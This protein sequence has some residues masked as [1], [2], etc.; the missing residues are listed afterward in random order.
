[1]AIRVHTQYVEALKGLGKTTKIGQWADRWEHTMK[2]IDKHKLPQASN[3][4]WLRD[5]AQA[6]KP[7]GDMLCILYGSQVRDAAQN[8]PT[9]YWMIAMQIRELFQ[10][11]AK[12]AQGTA[13]GSTFT[14]E[15][16]GEESTEGEP[17]EKLRGRSGQ[18]KHA[19]TCSIEVESSLT[20]KSK[21]QK[22]PACNIKSHSL[23]HCWTIFKSKRP[24][25]YKPNTALVKRVQEKLAKNKELKVEVEKIK[26]S[27]GIVDEA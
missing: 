12:K 4:L 10:S 17:K 26:L 14:V 23:A 7:L 5:I 22:Y 2:L 1:M 11:P 24:E 9:E 18:Q 6:V 16:V 27:E 25:G 13:R 15:I 19:G 8:K 3:G 21:N 20:K